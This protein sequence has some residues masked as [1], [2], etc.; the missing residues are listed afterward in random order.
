[1]SLETLP[2]GL[3]VE[4]GS[5]LPYKP[6][7]A[8]SWTCKQVYLTLPHRRPPGML[9]WMQLKGVGARIQVVQDHWYHY[10]LD[11]RPWFIFHHSDF[12]ISTFRC[13]VLMVLNVPVAEE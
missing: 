3:L 4:N 13:P 9:Q 5:Y 11:S 1:M 2:K 6:Y 7:V 8:V 10:T 12:L